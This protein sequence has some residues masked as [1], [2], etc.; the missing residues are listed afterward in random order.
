MRFKFSFIFVLFVVVSFAS[1]AQKKF[2]FDAGHAETAGNADWVI[3]KNSNGST[4]PSIPSPAQSGITSSTSETYWTGAISSW[5]V[6]LV[7]LGYY[8]ETL[9]SGTSITYNTSATQD[10][11]NYDVFVIDEPNTQFTAAEKTALIN[12]VK[13]GGG[14][15]MISDH[16]GS[17][18]NNDGWDSPKIWND[19]FTN[20]GMVTN[21]FGMSVDLIDISQTSTNVLVGDSLTA[22]PAGTV[23]GMQWSDGA[24]VTINNSAN[25]TAKGIVW[26]TGSTNGGITNCM[27]ARALYGN[28]KV[29]I[30]C[31]SSPADDGTGASGNSLYVGWAYTGP[32]VNG[33]HAYLHLNASIWL[34]NNTSLPVELTSFTSSVTN[35]NVKLIWNTAN[36]VNSFA[37]EIERKDEGSV[38]GW[39]K[40]GTINAS[41]NSSSPKNYS[42]LDNYISTGNYNYRLR[43]VDIDG[44]YKFSN[45]VNAG[46]LSPAKFDLGN[47]YPNPWNPTTTIRYNVPTNSPVTIKV[48]D[49][50][51]RE[52]A[53]LVD[54]VKPAGSYQITMNGKELSSGIYFYR[55][56]AGSFTETKKLILLK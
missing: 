30:V 49:A 7:K 13:N 24:T 26:T 10:L 45:V 51:G 5:G 53:S 6:A 41:G 27:V 39:Q 25:P 23:T 2:L 48:F 12:F 17:D 11:K 47:A 21:P 4:I 31:D 22:G 43:M 32:G 1:F 35:N 42:Y 16:T 15:F 55:M 19:L 54:E 36:E 8:V 40:I 33:S 28:G 29:V 44:S 38:D 52:V 46:V 3:S 56:T 34:A 20:N 18:R 14:L 37:F 9:P 50:V